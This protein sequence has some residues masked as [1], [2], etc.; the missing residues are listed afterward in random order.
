MH[1][2][3]FFKGYTQGI[4]QNDS[5]PKMFKLKDF[6]PNDSYE[7]VLPRHYD[8]FICALPLQEYTN[9]KTCVL[10][11]AAK[12]PPNMNKPDLGPK[13]YIAYGNAQ[14]LGSGNYV[15]YL[16]CDIADAVFIPAGC[17]HQVRNLK[18]C[19]KV[20]MDFVSP[21]SISECIRITQEF[22][23]LPAG[24]P[25]QEDD[26]LEVMK[27]GLS[28]AVTRIGIFICNRNLKSLLT[29]VNPLGG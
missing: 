14:E 25:S 29:C 26:K 28:S 24:H 11:I 22:R 15:T 23:K 3:K 1:A 21:E 6:P 17:P 18:S 20:A 7:E 8:E 10:N 27:F 9:P 5:Q 16:H 2:S 13:S 19:T 12:L 4:R